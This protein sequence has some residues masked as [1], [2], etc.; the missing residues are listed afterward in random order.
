MARRRSERLDREK[1]APVR[2]KDIFLCPPTYLELKYEI[3][4][5]MK[6]GAPFERAQAI[7]QWE[8]LVEAYR[9]VD[10]PGRIN[11]APA[12]EGR[13]EQYPSTDAGRLSHTKAR[14]PH[15]PHKQPE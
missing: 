14:G 7:E 15:P 12:K 3:N 6:K 4:P 11:I 1:I 2:P 13:T 5:W 9:K 8:S 10:A